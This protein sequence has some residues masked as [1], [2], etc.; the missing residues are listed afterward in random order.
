[1]VKFLGPPVAGGDATRKSSGGIEHL[2]SQ[3]D[4]I[5]TREL[6][7]SVLYDPINTAKDL[8]NLK[9]QKASQFKKGYHLGFAHSG[10]QSV[11]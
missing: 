3:R 5:D 4:S 8:E 7:G 1:M 2:F 6:Q 9:S 10:A 11:I